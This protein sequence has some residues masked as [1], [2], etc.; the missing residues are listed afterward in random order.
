M[1]LL[2]KNMLVQFSLMLLSTSLFS[3]SN[4]SLLNLPVSNKTCDG[5]K[6]KKFF[7]Q[8]FESLGVKYLDASDYKVDKGLTPPTPAT[9]L[10]I[11]ERKNLQTYRQ[12]VA[13]HKEIAW[14]LELIDDTVGYG[15]F[16][17]EDIIR[18]Q[19]VAEY[20]GAMVNEEY[21]NEH[22]PF[23]LK[24]SWTVMPPIYCAA[25]KKF[26]VDALNEGNFTRYINHSYDPNVL[27]L[28]VYCQNEWHMIYVACK[29]IKM[30]Q[31]LLV[32]YG[33]GYWYNRE[34]QDLKE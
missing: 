1:L 32:D 33:K 7:R 23:D 21:I 22:Q 17:D 24:Y 31:Q 28:V 2:R 27:A 25:P 30:G 9:S 14:H 20:T 16:A 5:A 26:V 13:D 10:S 3:D 18:G 4:Q 8:D 29:E 6:V 34:P 12:D 19:Y 11:N 15:V